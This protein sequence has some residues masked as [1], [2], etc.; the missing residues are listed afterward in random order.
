MKLTVRGLLRA[1]AHNHLGRWLSLDHGWMAPDVGRLIVVSG[2]VQHH[3]NRQS[4]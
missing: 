1:D 4:R 2:H 3:D